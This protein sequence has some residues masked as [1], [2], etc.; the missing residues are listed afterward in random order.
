MA[1]VSQQ[2]IQTFNERYYVCHNYSQVARETGFSASTVRKYI[3]K[4]WEPPIV[5][6]I[7]KFSDEMYGPYLAQFQ[8]VQNFGELCELS[9][10]EGEE[11]K[12][13]WKEMSV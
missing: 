3:I 7:I 12:E 1:K 4:D 10:E 2:D 13:L 11:L 9:A 8:S 6:N 5:A